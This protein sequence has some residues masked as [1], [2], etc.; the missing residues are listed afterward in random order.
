MKKSKRRWNQKGFTLIESIITLVLVSIMAA[1]L[2]TFSQPLYSSLGAFTWFND[3]LLLQQSMEKILGDYKSQRNDPYNP[4][5]P[6][7]FRTYVISKPSYMV[8]ASKTGF[9]TFTCSGTAP[10]ITCTAAWPPQSTTPP[11]IV[12]PVLIITV[13]RNNMTLSMIVT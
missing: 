2:L 11:G 7:A 3:E 6:N 1:M 8:D 12:P 10:N 9:L 5:D 13:S 4:F